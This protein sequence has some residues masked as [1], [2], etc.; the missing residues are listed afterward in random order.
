L[1]IHI[2]KEG[3]FM[4]IQ[5]KSGGHS[6]GGPMKLFWGQS[7][8]SVTEAIQQAAEAAKKELPGATLEW[9]ELAE[10]RG[11]FDQGKLQFQVS[12]RIGYEPA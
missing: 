6:F 3:I 1:F 10:I 11:G 5:S 7:P 2:H 4:H 8:V 12:V 9:M